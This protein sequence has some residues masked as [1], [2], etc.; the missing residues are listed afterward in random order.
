MGMITTEE[1]YDAIV[2]QINT[3]LDKQAWTSSEQ[4]LLTL[5]GTLVMAYEDVHYPDE[6]FVLQKTVEPDGGEFV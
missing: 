5:L 4:D 1:E 3:L 2:A 6:T